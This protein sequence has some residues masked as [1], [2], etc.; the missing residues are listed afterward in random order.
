MLCWNAIHR[1]YIKL[2]SKKKRLWAPNISLKLIHSHSRPKFGWVS[3]IKPVFYM[4]TDDYQFSLSCM[5]VTS[6]CTTRP[7][8]GPTPKAAILTLSSLKGTQDWKF[9]WLRFWNLRFF[10]VSYVKILRFYKKNLRLSG[11]I[12]SPPIM[13]IMAWSKIFLL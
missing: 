10:F 7:R 11:K 6:F 9:V 1:F 5:K 12:V 8:R 2:Q 13:A 4:S 3:K